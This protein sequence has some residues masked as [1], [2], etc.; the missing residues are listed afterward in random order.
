[1]EKLNEIGTFI[2]QV[3]LNK[4][5]TMEHVAKET[6]MSRATLFAIE[7]GDKNYSVGNL[8]S[9]INY[10]G[11][12]ISLESDICGEI[13][14]NRASRMNKKIDKKINRF[15]IMCIEMYAKY[16]SKS[17]K[18]IYS[19]FKENGVIKLL[20]DG[21][22]DLHSM[23]TEWINNYVDSILMINEEKWWIIIWLKCWS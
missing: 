10:L 13:S 17:G 15:I 20:E 16:K 18:D 6:G 14:R 22:K 8:I 1:M 7:K 2:K 23:G 9:L 19:I 4:N 11:I 12:S 21:Y 3:R 5:L